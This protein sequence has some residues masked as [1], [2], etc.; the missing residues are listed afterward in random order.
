MAASGGTGTTHLLREPVPATAT[1]IFII[2]KRKLA[3]L[4][5]KALEI[6]WRWRFFADFLIRN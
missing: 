4:L 2:V 3:G 1:T 5:R 6:V